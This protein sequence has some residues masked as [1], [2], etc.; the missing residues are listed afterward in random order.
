MASVRIDQ[1]A[2]HN[3]LNSENGDIA[4]E[5]LKRAIQV[6]RSA[7]RYCPVRTGRLRASITHSLEHDARGIYATVGSN[8]H[9]AIYV[10]MGTRHM[11]ARSYLRPALREHT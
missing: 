7:K 6:E 10:E 1:G 2:I 3:L 4:K 9:Y 11:R 8:V 5:L